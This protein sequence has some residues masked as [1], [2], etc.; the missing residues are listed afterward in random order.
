MAVAGII[1]IYDGKILIL[2]SSTN[3]VE[4]ALCLWR[5]KLWENQFHFYVQNTL[6]TENVGGDFFSV[7]SMIINQ[8]GTINRNIDM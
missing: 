5:K 7:E 2:A 8:K 3:T 1:M 4:R 6:W